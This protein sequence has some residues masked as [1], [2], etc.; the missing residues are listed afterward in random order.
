LHLVGILFP[1]ILRI[2]LAIGSLNILVNNV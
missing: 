2:S 1:Q